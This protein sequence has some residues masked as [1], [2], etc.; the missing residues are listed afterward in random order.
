METANFNGTEIDRFSRDEFA[1]IALL[2]AGLA[3]NLMALLFDWLA[4]KYDI[5]FSI[6]KQEISYSLPVEIAAEIGIAYGMV[7]L[8]RRRIIGIIFLAV[9]FALFVWESL[10]QP[11]VRWIE[12][13]T[14]GAL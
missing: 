4:M 12:M 5:G 10:N 3:L 11:T 9:V 1:G 6:L 14:L 8:F 13:H 2:W 7:L